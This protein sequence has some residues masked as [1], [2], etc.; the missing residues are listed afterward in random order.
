MVVFDA[1]IKRFQAQAEK[2]GWTYIN[3]P[4]EIASQLKPGSRLTFR[5]KGKLDNVK[6][7][8]LSVLPMG[9]GDFILTLNKQLR[10]SIAKPLG[11]AIKVQLTHDQRELEIFPELLA[12]LKDE[13]MAYK[14]FMKLTP[15]HQRYFSKWVSD[16]K[17]DQTRVKRM[18]VTVNAML[19]NKNFGE[20]LKSDKNF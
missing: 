4:A 20:A 12:C 1:V 10:K 17:T 5:V 6:I 2:T 18:A 14:T 9:N 19:T 13:P 11:A 8:K 7:K 16:A 3:I 15:S